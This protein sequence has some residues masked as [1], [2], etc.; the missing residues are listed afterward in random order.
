M[1]IVNYQPFIVVLLVIAGFITACEPEVACL[2]PGAANFSPGADRDC[3][4]ECCV[5]PQLGLRFFLRNNGEPYSL[6]D[7]LTDAAGNA[8]VLSDVRFYMTDVKLLRD[9]GEAVGV[10]DSVRLFFNDGTN[11]IYNDN[12]IL[13]TANTFSYDVGEIVES[14]DFTAMEFDVGLDETANQVFADTMSVTHPLSSENG[15]YI[16]AVNGYLFNE[17]ELTIIPD[18]IPVSYGISGVQNLQ[19][20][21]VDFDSTIT[22]VKGFDIEIQLEVDYPKLLEGVDLI[23]D[24]DNIIQGKIVT[25]TPDIFSLF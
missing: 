23:N 16:D 18:S 7:T 6:S 10:T 13:A 25:N 22:L 24:T 15:M 1:K 11:G 12:Y 19:A 9:N 4:T 14:G 17:V 3:G 5:Y 21:T 2:D 8:F 20:V